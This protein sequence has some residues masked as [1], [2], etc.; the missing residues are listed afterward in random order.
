M[1]TIALKDFQIF[2]QAKISFEPGLTVI[3]GSNSSGKSSIMRAIRTL[4]D[5]NPYARRFIRHGTDKAVVALQLEGMPPIYWQRGANTVAYKIGDKLF[6]KCGKSKLHD[7]MPEFPFLRD[8]SGSSLNMVDEWTQ[9]FPFGH[10]AADLFRIF[11]D[12]FSTSSGHVVEE[13]RKDEMMVRRAQAENQSLIQQTRF[14]LNLVDQ[15]LEDVNLEKLESMKNEVKEVLDFREI[16][17]RDQKCAEE[18]SIFQ[19]F[20]I[21]EHPNLAEAEETIS[22][23]QAVRNA[24]LLTEIINIQIDTVG[25]DLSDVENVFE[26]IEDIKHA[27]AAEAISCFEF[28]QAPTL[29]LEGTFMLAADYMAAIVLNNDINSVL[30]QMEQTR[31]EDEENTLKLAEYDFCPLCGHELGDGII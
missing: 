29:D 22:S 3:T 5:N 2:S 6:T 25:V 1:I 9:P 10:S 11:E 13:V 8:D 20:E 16:A 26:M 4:G 30:K 7:L 24:N 18:C 23:L 19:D 31:K 17:K 28:D 14:R 27:N 21:G 12:L 15:T